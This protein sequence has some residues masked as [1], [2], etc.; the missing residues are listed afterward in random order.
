[1]WSR[2]AHRRFV[3]SINENI[4]CFVLFKLPLLFLLLLLLFNRKLQTDGKDSIGDML[5]HTNQTYTATF[6]PD[7]AIARSMLAS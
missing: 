1:M 7:A 3:L 5:S 2:I 6:R 4:F